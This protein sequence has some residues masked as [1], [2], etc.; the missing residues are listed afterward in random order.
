MAPVTSRTV[1]AMADFAA[2]V[3]PTVTVIDCA[4]VRAAELAEYQ[5]SPSACPV[6]TLVVVDP[7]AARAQWLDAESVT[8]VT[9]ASVAWFRV[10]IIATSKSPAPV[11]AVGFTDSVALP[12]DPLAAPNDWTTLAD[13]F[14]KLIGAGEARPARKSVAD[15]TK[16]APVAAFPA[17]QRPRRRL[18][19]VR[20]LVADGWTQV[21][22]R[23]QASTR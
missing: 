21:V 11:A 15:A 17:R 3:P 7:T 1:N 23:C 6:L 20:V 18:S 16:V 13:T 19:P 12:D 9:G 8:P 14:A 22:S 10:L 5:I 4:V 2:E